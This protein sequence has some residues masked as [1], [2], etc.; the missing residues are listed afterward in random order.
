MAVSKF[1]V[2]VRADLPGFGPTAAQLLH[3]GIELSRSKPHD[4]LVETWHTTSN[5]VVVATVPDEPALKELAA[6]LPYA[7]SFREPDMKGAMTALAVIDPP[8]KLVGGLPLLG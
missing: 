1:M 8:R 3:A 6:Q 4:E 2:V 5:T 7:V